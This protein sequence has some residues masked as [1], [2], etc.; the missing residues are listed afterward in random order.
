MVKKSS[1]LLALKRL[2]QEHSIA[3]IY[4]SINYPDKCSVGFIEGISSEHII[5]KHISR[6][7]FYDGY[8]I[9]RIDDIF[10]VD[11]GGQYEKKILTLYTAQNQKHDSLI[12]VE[13]NEETDI[14]KECLMSSMKKNYVVSLFIDETENEEYFYGWVKDVSHEEVIISRI[15]SEGEDDGTAIIKACEITALNCDTDDEIVL[16][17]LNITQIQ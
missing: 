5:M 16:K 9:R 8:V 14:L 13:I 12:D 11:F 2:M 1:I 4:P 7:G 17:I 15:S 10:R 3:S 6:N